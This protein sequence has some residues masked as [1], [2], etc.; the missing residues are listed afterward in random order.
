MATSMEVSVHGLA[1]YACI[2]PVDAGRRVSKLQS[3]A[4]QPRAQ[5]RLHRGSGK[6]C[7][8]P[9][10][11]QGEELPLALQSTIRHHLPSL[12]AA[13]VT[14]VSI[15]AASLSSPALALEDVTVA[16]PPQLLATLAEGA[17]DSLGN[18]IQFVYLGALLL[19]LGAGGF[20]VARQL[21]IRRQ[22]ELTAKDLQE[23]VRLGEATAEEY[24]ELGAVMLRKKLHFMAMKH[25]KNAITKWE[26]EEEDLAQV[27]NALGFAHFSENEIKEAITAYEKSVQLQPAYVTAWNNLGNAK[28]KQKDYDGAV[29]CYK[30]ALSYDRDNK[31]AKEQLDILERKRARMGI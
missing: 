4:R 8:Q 26:G 22:L 3:L 1:S 24:Y 5:N 6:L 2:T 12:S 15:A 7:P 21:L 9:S 18:N 16:L 13:T 23:R 31:I 30:Q 28:E 27:Y 10:L 29:Q 14:A 25:L 19:L 11:R 17:E 20:L